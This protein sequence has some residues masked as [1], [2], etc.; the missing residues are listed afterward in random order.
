MFGTWTC[1]VREDGWVGD[2]DGR[3]ST[4]TEDAEGA[5]SAGGMGGV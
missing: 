2:D 1:S 5:E 4:T 3:G